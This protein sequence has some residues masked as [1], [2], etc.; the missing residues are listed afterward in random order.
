M[1]IISRCSLKAHFNDVQILMGADIISERKKLEEKVI[2]NPETILT[3]EY[4]KKIDDG[5]RESDEL[6][7]KDYMKLKIE[8]KK[9]IDDLQKMRGRE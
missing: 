5:E 2:E 8:W 9:K 4:V 1:V 7:K 3:F 6:A